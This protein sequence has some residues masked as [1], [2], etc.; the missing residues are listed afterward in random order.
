ME[1]PAGA[2][3]RDIEWYAYN[4]SGSAARALAR[5]WVTGGGDLSGV[6]A[7]ADIG[8]T[9][10]IG[11]QR[12]VVPSTA[13]G[14]YPAGSRLL[15]GF[16]ANGTGVLQVNGV[17]VG[18][19]RGAGAVGVLPAPKRIYDSRKT[20]LFK[21]KSTRTVTVPASVAPVGVSALLLTVTA[22]SGAA[23]GAITV[24]PDGS[25]RPGVTSL[26]HGKSTVSGTILVPVPPDRKL[27]IYAT[28]KVHVILDAMATIG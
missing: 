27:K 2:L 11:A 12:V 14:P 7:D 23:T 10:G 26:N 9:T 19:T 13:Y 8:P 3:V 5:V 18:F 20:S 6:V 24:Y 25:A 4:A 22:R 17:R 28:K 16:Q 15:L 21:A 1:I